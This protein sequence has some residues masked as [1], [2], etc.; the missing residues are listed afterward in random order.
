MRI[1]TKT[2]Q[3]DITP[4]LQAYIEKRFSSVAKFVQSLEHN[5]EISLY[6][7]LARTSQHHR[8]GEKVYYV[9]CTIEI[10]SKMVRIE[11]YSSDIRKAI[12]LARSRLKRELRQLKESIQD[13]HQE[14][15]REKKVSS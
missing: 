10:Y 6:V 12:D 11:Q 2:T 5:S 15:G 3:L 1:I 9:E 14:E 8:K 7:E 13:K 4:A